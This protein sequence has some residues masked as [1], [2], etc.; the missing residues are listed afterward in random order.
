[1][2]KVAVK[3][4]RKFAAKDEAAK[5][6]ADKTYGLYDRH[7]NFYIGNK[8]VVIID[9]NIVVDGEEE[10]EGTPGLWELIVSKNL[11]DKIILR[12]DLEN[13]KRLIIKTNAL[14]R[15]NDPKSVYPKRSKGYQW[16][17]T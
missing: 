10:Y 1:M 13:Y 16:N 7:G 9:N 4:L 6:E 8:L 17:N 3:N 2:G 15:D 12:N 5:D 14:Y 11:G